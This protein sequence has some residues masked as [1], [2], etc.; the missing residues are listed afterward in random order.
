M[1]GNKQRAENPS[2]QQVYDELLIRC[3]SF[4]KIHSAD[5]VLWGGGGGMGP[6]CAGAVMGQIELPAN[7]SSTFRQV[8]AD[9]P[10]QCLLQQTLT[11]GRC[12]ERQCRVGFSCGLKPFFKNK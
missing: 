4:R 5:G 6:G 2:D 3:L 7:P 10:A 8:K 1:P 9:P 12:K 11:A